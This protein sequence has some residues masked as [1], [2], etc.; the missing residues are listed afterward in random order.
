M[1]ARVHLPFSHFQHL[2]NKV[3]VLGAAYYV[4]KF[5]TL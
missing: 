5:G 2:L 4:Q 3:R 1:Y